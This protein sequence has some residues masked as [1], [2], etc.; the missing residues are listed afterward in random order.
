MQLYICSTLRHLLFSLSRACVENTKSHVVFLVDHQNI[1]ESNLD[2]ENLPEHITVSKVSRRHLANEVKY[3]LLGKLT[4]FLSMRELTAPTYIKNSL[5]DLIEKEVDTLKLHD[6][7]A[8]FV[9]N[10]RNKTAR[11]FRLIFEKYSIIEDGLLNYARRTLPLAKTIANYLNGNFS[12]KRIAGEDPNCIAI[13]AINPVGLPSEIS[14]KGIKVDFLS[15]EKSLKV[16]HDTFKLESLPKQYVI[17]ATQP[18]IGYFER[19]SLPTNLHIE[20]Y[21]K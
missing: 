5:I 13:Y 21:K 1:D 4:Y 7:T 8:L 10:E 11:L 14:D 19:L 17:L 9:F 18:V 2:F 16:I 20:I 6:V 12:N 3:T 15:H